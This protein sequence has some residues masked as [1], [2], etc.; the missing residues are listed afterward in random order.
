MEHLFN[1]DAIESE[2]LDHAVTAEGTE[3]MLGYLR[4]LTQSRTLKQ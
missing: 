2:S 1:K 3:E 4:E